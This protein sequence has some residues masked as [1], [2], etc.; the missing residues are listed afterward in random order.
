[1]NVLIN[2]LRS[3]LLCWT[4]LVVFLT[5]A[6]SMIPNQ[7]QVRSETPV[8]QKDTDFDDVSFLRT[9]SSSFVSS[10]QPIR[11]YSLS[12]NEGDYHYAPKPKHL[13]HNRLLRILGSSFDPFWM[14][15]E[16]PAEAR[17]DTDASAGQTAS[18]GDPPAPP[19]LPNYTT[20]EGFNFGASPELT[21]GAAR[22][23][24]KLQN[25]AED[26]DLSELPADVASTLRDWLVRSATCGMRYQWVQLAP[27]F[28]PRWLRHTD[29]EK[30]GGSRSCSFPSGMACRQAQTTQIKILAWHC[31]SSEERGGD[32]LRGMAGIDRET[33]V[34][35]TGVAGRKCLW[36]QVPYPVVTAC[37]CSCK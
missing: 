4:Y 15:I 20:N 13:R 16:R 31:W 8:G 32:G 18:R 12:M 10:S 35:G 34:V 14:S 19:A 33:V 28:W 30:S 11:P 1:M 7:E 3:V 2:W 21:E 17:V 27:V 26:L 6:T 5:R 36:R 23:Q 37:K 29:C 25:D 24:R 22:Y 9:R